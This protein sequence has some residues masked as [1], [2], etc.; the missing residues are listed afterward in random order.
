MR[1]GQKQGRHTRKKKL[2]GSLQNIKNSQ[3]KS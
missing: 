1:E 3:E 2:K